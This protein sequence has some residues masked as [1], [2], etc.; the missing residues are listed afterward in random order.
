ML[1]LL[2][3]VFPCIIGMRPSC[4]LPTLLIG[5]PLVPSS[6]IRHFRFLCLCLAAHQSLTF[7][8]EFSVAWLLSMSMANQTSSFFDVCLWGMLLLKMAIGVITLPLRKYLSLSMSFFMKRRCILVLL[9]PH[10]RGSF[11]VMKFVCLI[12]EPSSKLWCSHPSPN[13]RPLHSSLPSSSKLWCSSRL[14]SSR[15]ICNS[16]PPNPCD[17][18]T[19]KFRAGYCCTTASCRVRDSRRHG[20]L[21]PLAGGTWGYKRNSTCQLVS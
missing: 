9:S 16:L 5:F 2:R 10:F 7:P 17:C 14:P 4:L 12:M 3:H 13:G 21:D 1:L 11:K 8:L 18:T 15:P 6:F 20:P 19:A